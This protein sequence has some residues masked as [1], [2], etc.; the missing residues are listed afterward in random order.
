VTHTDMNRNTVSV[1]D[2]SQEHRLNRFF[3]WLNATR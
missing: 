2:S 1:T 3:I